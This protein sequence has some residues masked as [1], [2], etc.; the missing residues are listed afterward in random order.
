[1]HQMLHERQD[2]SSSHY[3]HRSRRFSVPTCSHDTSERFQKTNMRP[4]AYQT[5]I[6]ITLLDED[7]KYT[8]DF[9]FILTNE[10]Q[11]KDWS[12]AL[13]QQ[14][15]NAV[16]WNEFASIS[17]NPF[18]LKYDNEFKRPIHEGDSI[19]GRTMTNTDEAKAGLREPLKRGSRRRVQSVFQDVPKTTL[20]DESKPQPKHYNKQDKQ[21]SIPEP[22]DSPV[23]RPSVKQ[24]SIIQKPKI[25]ETKPAPRPRIIDPPQSQ[26]KSSTNTKLLIN[27]GYV[28]SPTKTSPR[29][30]RKPRDDTP[31]TPTNSQASLAPPRTKPVND[32][33]K[34]NSGLLY[35]ETKSRHQKVTLEFQEDIVERNIIQPKPHRIPRPR[36]EDQ[37]PLTPSRPSFETRNKVPP[38]SYVI[39]LNVGMDDED[40]S[41]N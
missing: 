3:S 30:I 18:A 29:M 20:E 2:G 19:K 25:I 31:S 40:A 37:R 14:I 8:R 22:S 16:A 9:I 41:G 38:N 27:H 21:T 26:T 23:P 15:T 6:R 39:R 12:F 36:L 35:S 10:N 33:T 28:S 34:P 4:T 7:T 32:P 13:Q 24:P 1:M 5:A 11:V 17:T